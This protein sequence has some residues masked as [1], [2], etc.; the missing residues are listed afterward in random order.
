PVDVALVVDHTSTVVVFAT[1]SCACPAYHAPSGLSAPNISGRLILNRA[2]CD[3]VDRFHTSIGVAAERSDS[4][5]AATAINGLGAGASTTEFAL[6]RTPA[7]AA[8]AS[9]K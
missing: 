1:S 3:L 6:N 2:V 4:G 7:S 9:R 5:A 8:I